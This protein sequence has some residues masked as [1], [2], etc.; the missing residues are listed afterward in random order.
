[1][2][3]IG[4]AGSANARARGDGLA[5]SSASGATDLRAQRDRVNDW[6]DR[7]VAPDASTRAEAL[8]EFDR[9]T[10]DLL[11]AIDDKLNGLAKSADHAAMSDVVA[12]VIKPRRVPPDEIA[13]RLAD[14][15]FGKSD[16]WLL[17]VMG[18]PAP[19][20]AGWRD[21]ATIL[22]LSR[23]LVHIGTTSAARSLA[24]L[25]PHYGDVMRPDHERHLL[26]LGAMAHLALIEMRRAETKEHRAF[27][28][29]VLEATGK[30]IPGEAVQAGDDRLLV[31]V[32]LSYGKAHELDALRVILSFANSDRR[33]IRE[34]AREAVM[35]MGPIGA[36][37]LRDAYENMMSKKPQDGWE[38]DVT[39]RE[40]FLAYDRA[41]LA[42]A[43]ALMDEGLA[44]FQINDPEKAV[45]A[46][47]RV[48]AR[49]PSFPR[50]AEMAPAYLAYART[51]SAS[52]PDR[53]EAALRSALRVDPRGPLA[54]S[55]E[56]SLLVLEARERAARG[57]VDESSLSRAL[58]LDP[59]NA[60]AKVDLL[61]I[62]SE[63]RTRGSRLTLYICSAVAAL[64]GAAGV[65][66]FVAHRR[67][68]T[69]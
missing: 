47:D 50:R 55:A 4:G 17:L 60:E 56:S 51:L 14:G 64:F 63:R 35:K 65:A 57:V 1:M 69:G 11:P 23:A 39:A 48:L 54:R 49:D 45:R 32:L 59:Q 26:T 52:A 15:G 62:E 6:L 40:L 3:E 5:P 18:A 25:Y 29:K 22:A 7:L 67:R 2:A 46:F 37:E 10:P 58:E 61:R 43:Y 38:W 19:S 8:T 34:A 31:E 44:A 21:L 41:R 9:I 27:A 16:D 28:L 13:G 68:S 20:Q 36:R 53:A 33:P 24:A 30:A 42:E 12:S 66:T